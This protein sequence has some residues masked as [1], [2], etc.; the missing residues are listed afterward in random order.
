MKSKNK[1]NYIIGAIISFLIIPII[2]VKGQGDSF[3]SGYNEIIYSQD[4]LTDYIFVSKGYIFYDVESTNI[5]DFYILTPEGYDKFILTEDIGYVDVEDIIHNS[6]DIIGETGVIRIHTGY[7]YYLLFINDG[8][9]NVYLDYYF[10]GMTIYNTFDCFELYLNMIIVF[11]CIGIIIGILLGILIGRL[12]KK[13]QKT[14]NS[15]I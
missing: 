11:L 14:K 5:I 4:Y 8:Y 2:L 7:Q 12:L 1:N 15:I 6:K 3:P 13:R 9:T 10:A